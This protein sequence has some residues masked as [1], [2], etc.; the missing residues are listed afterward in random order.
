MRAENKDKL[1][2]QAEEDTFRELVYSKLEAAWQDI[3]WQKR[4]ANLPLE[5]R[6]R[7]TMWWLFSFVAEQAINMGVEEEAFLQ[8]MQEAY[9]AVELEEGEEGNERPI[10]FTPVD[11]PTALIGQTA[12]IPDA[13]PTSPAPLEP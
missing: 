4:L 2:Q 5:Q 7:D 8:G 3:E 11:A 13:V 6:D 12:A 1:K 10:P 9:R